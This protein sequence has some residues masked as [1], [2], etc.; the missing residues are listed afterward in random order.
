MVTRRPVNSAVVPHPLTYEMKSSPP[1]IYREPQPI[2]RQEAERIFAHGTSADVATALVDITFHDPDW[3]WLQDKCLAFTGNADA[4]VRQIAIT[5]LG[6]VAR[7][8]GRL[9]LETVLPVL[10][11]LSTDS[12]L[13]TDD[14]LDDI[15]MFVET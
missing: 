9:D 3:Q 8:H 14:A 12:A 1:L 11:K 15:R 4:S 5:C 7:I 6:H 13:V 10:D 2:S